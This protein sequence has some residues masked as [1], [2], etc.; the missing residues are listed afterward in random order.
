ME[1]GERTRK[2]K[3]EELDGEEEEEWSPLSSGEKGPPE[4]QEPQTPFRTPKMAKMNSTVVGKS[5]PVEGEEEDRWFMSS[6]PLRS[7]PLK[8]SPL[9]V[10]HKVNVSTSI[11]HISASPIPSHDT[12][13]NG[14]Y[15]TDITRY[16]NLSPFVSAPTTAASGNYKEI[17]MRHPHQRM[18]LRVSVGEDG[19]AVVRV[20][21]GELH[22]PYRDVEQLAMHAPA[23]PL[24]DYDRSTGNQQAVL[25]YIDPYMT[26]MPCKT[27]WDGVHSPGGPGSDEDW[28]RW[29]QGSRKDP[30]V[31][32]STGPHTP[33]SEIT[34][35]PLMALRKSLGLIN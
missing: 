11:H 9:Q 18:R 8:T 35:A 6:S 10:H 22:G 26:T 32:E 23:T 5:S 1:R 2:R 25:K 16:V 12:S 4:R 14:S 30:D 20:A 21:S 19:F 13:L 24:V 15:D 17:A 31:H 27:E 7:S 29:S 33:I 28:D 3:T 34:A